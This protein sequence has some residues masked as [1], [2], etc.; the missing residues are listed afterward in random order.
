MEFTFHAGMGK[1]DLY[2][3]L[4]SF[5]SFSHKGVMV[6]LC[7]NYEPVGPKHITL[8]Q[9]IFRARFIFLQLSLF[10]WPDCFLFPEAPMGGRIV[11]R[12]DWLWFTSP[13]SGSQL[14]ATYSCLIQLK[15]I[16]TTVSWIKA[17][18]WSAIG[19][20][21]EGSCHCSRALGGLHSQADF[22]AFMDLTKVWWWQPVNILTVLTFHDLR[23]KKS[24]SIF[25]MTEF[26]MLLKCEFMH[27]CS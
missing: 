13:D 1:T 19:S 25:S 10:T 14:W 20:I 18:A 7:C 8:A 21:H 3:F 27:G 17:L 9:G 24:R 6:V 22:W 12:L 11:S 23:Q 16:F 5:S 2:D 26:R 15:C 4:N